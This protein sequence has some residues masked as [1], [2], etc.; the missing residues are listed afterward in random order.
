MV[1]LNNNPLIPA[2]VMFCFTYIL[3]T[4]TPPLSSPQ[5]Q[6]QQKK[7]RR[8]V[9][10]IEPEEEEEEEE[11]QQQEDIDDPL[12]DYPMTDDD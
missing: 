4:A 8:V 6:L 2:L 9:R 5:S 7:R 12:G 3:F 11:Q 10:V 1:D